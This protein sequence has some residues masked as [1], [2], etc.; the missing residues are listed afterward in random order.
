MNGDLTV[1]LPEGALN[2]RVGAILKKG[3][4]L[5]MVW[6]GTGA[7]WYTIGGRVRFGESSLQAVKRELEEELGEQAGS[8]SEGEL[9]AVSENFFRIDGAR[10]HEIGYYYLFDAS[11]LSLKAGDRV[12]DNDER[13]GWLSEEEIKRER[14]FPLFLKEEIPSGG[15]IR[16]I[17]TV[18]EDF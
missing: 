5:L 14:L 6:S 12:C 18:E 11:A 9:V 17:V 16:H 8:L 3:N 4:K 1:K 10:F 2:V 15:K 7:H 13:L